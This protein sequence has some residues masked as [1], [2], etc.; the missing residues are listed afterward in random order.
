MIKQ[1]KFPLDGKFPNEVTKFLNCRKANLSNEYLELEAKIK[2]LRQEIMQ[3]CGL[4]EAKIIRNL[5]FAINDA[6]I[7][8]LEN[9]GKRLLDI[10]REIKIIDIIFTFGISENWDENRGLN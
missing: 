6:T 8:E 2:A 5:P 1:I 10:Y 9:A 3:L 7:K 4:A